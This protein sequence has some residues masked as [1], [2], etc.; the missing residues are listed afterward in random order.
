MIQDPNFWGALAASVVVFWLLPKGYRD[1]FLAAA[2]F[3]YL[4]FLE[5]MTVPLLAVLTL[6]VFTISPKTASSE[7]AGPWAL[8]GLILALLGYLAYFKYIPQFRAATSAADAAT[9]TLIPLGV[10]YYTFKFIHYAVEVARG[11]VE[12]RSLQRLFCYVFLFPTF[13]AGPI[14]RFDHFLANRDDGFE[15]QSLVEGCTRIIH[16]LVKLLIFAKIFMTARVSPEIGSADT[17]LENLNEIPVYYVWAFVLIT[18]IRAYLDFS[19]YSDIAIGGARLFG[20]RIM[21]NFNFPVIAWNIREFWRRWHMTLAAWCQAYVY[22][23]LIGHT[24]QPY[25]AIYATFVT[26]GIW[27]GASWNWL[28]WG[29]YHATGVA[30]QLTWNR[31][32]RRIGWASTDKRWRLLTTPMTFAFV[33]GSYAF[34]STDQHSIG[35]GFRIFCKLFGLDLSE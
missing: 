19:A 26:M 22:L 35:A 13:S 4:V 3:G 32:S 23:P 17:L 27:H 11:N 20:I 29:L 6:A 21:E 12:D 5:P 8:P 24:R 18:Y 33:S 34:S 30:A 9:A 31:Y 2:S 28:A 16:G 1:G 25:L 15:L 14:E 7:G 10:S